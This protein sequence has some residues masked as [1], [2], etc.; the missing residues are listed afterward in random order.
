MDGEGE[1]RLGDANV[2]TVEQIWNGPVLNRMREA[3]WNQQR[4]VQAKCAK[5][6]VRHWELF[7]Q[8]RTH[9]LDPSA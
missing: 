3:F 5:C 9:E 6:D 4:A 2:E 7:H 8:Y 1:I